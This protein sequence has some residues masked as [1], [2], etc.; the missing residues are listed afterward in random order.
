M[1]QASFLFYATAIFVHFCV[2]NRLFAPGLG[3]LIFDSKCT[4]LGFSV[5]FL[6]LCRR[7]VC[8]S[9]VPDEDLIFFCLNWYRYFEPK[10]I[11]FSFSLRFCTKL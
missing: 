6:N 1:R 9:K 2:D 5:S 11:M 8:D 4:R 3:A 10:D 7:V